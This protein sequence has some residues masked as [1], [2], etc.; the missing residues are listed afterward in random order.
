M[1]V[2][3]PRL[4]TRFTKGL[5]HYFTKRN[6]NIQCFSLFVSVLICLFLTLS[7]YFL[8]FSSVGLRL[9][10]MFFFLFWAHSVHFLNKNLV[11]F[12]REHFLHFYSGKYFAHLTAVG[13]FSVCC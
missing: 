10:F 2:H 5:F 3:K 8:P 4:F 1:C 12:S 13:E 6:R 7:Y 9:S 11:I